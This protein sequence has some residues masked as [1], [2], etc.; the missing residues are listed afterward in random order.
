MF[1]AVFLTLKRKKVWVK[2]ALSQRASVTQQ[3]VLATLSSLASAACHLSVSAYHHTEEMSS[4]SYKCLLQPGGPSCP[5][6]P[7]QL[8]R[9]TAS[10]DLGTLFKMAFAWDPL[11]ATVPGPSPRS[12]TRLRFSKSYRYG[13]FLSESREAFFAALGPLRGNFVG[14]LNSHGCLNCQSLK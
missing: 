10:V 14:L 11:G 2:Q 6:V 7:Y 8:W 3:E 13:S 9:S 5:R 12:R 4:F 1:K